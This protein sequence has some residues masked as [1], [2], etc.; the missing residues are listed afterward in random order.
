M[1]RSVARAIKAEAQATDFVTTTVIGV[2]SRQLD[3]KLPSRLRIEI[4]ASNVVYHELPFDVVGR[5]SSAQDK[6]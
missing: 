6:T 2:F 1:Q 4:C 3:V 5:R